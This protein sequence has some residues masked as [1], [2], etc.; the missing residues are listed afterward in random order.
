MQSSARQE[1]KLDETI[2][3]LLEDAGG[4]G[5][6]Q[7]LIVLTWMLSDNGVFVIILAL[8]ILTKVPTEY[9]CTRTGNFDDLFSCTPADFCNDTSTISSYEPN[10]DLTDSYENWIGRYGLE[11]ASGAKIGIIG[12]A[13]FVGWVISL[14]IVPRV[15]DTHGRQKLLLF[16]NISSL[17]AFT[18]MLISTSYEV[19]IG[20]MFTLGAMST[21]RV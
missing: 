14:L 1:E 18:I 17:V 20:C 9:F 6:L 16:G 5:K 12:S 4:F 3:N 15:S 11:C 19:L 21:I 2:D 7:L 10:M 13:F 8:S